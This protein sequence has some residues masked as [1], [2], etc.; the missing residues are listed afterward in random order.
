ML[1]VPYQGSDR[2]LHPL[3]L[4]PLPW[5]F[6]LTPHQSTFSLSYWEN[7]V[8]S[9]TLM[10]ILQSFSPASPCFVYLT[11]CHAMPYQTTKRTLVTFLT[12]CQRWCLL[13]LQPAC[14]HFPIPGAIPYHAIPYQEPQ[15]LSVILS[16]M[17]LPSS[18]ASLLGTKLVYCPFYLL[19]KTKLIL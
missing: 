10:L 1:Y 3:P 15:S 8:A 12:C 19:H 13:L 4:L 11:K 9:I 14:G 6:A 7:D 17:P 16:S 2:C 18:L 5:C